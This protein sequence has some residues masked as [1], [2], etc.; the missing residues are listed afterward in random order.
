MKKSALSLILMLTSITSHASLV[1]IMDSGTD[2]SNSKLAAKAWV[3]SKEVVGMQDRDGDGLA[4][5]KFGWDF[6]TNSA[7]FFDGKYASAYREDAKKFFETIAKYDQGIISK[8]ELEWLKTAVKNEKLMLLT[9]FMGVYNHGT[10]VAGIASSGSDLIKIMPLKVLSAEPPP[11]LFSPAPTPISIP[12]QKPAG[13]TGYTFERFRDEVRAEARNNV[14]ELVKKV[15]VLNF[16]KV[17]TA[18]QSYGI[19]FKNVA[20][21]IAVAYRE[22]FAESITEQ[23]LLDLTKDFFKTIEGASVAVG[24]ANPYTLFVISAGNDS[25]N[26]DQL[27]AFPANIKIENKITVAATNGYM[28]LADFSNY[29]ANNVDVAA[30]GVGIQSTAVNQSTVY[31]SGTSQAAPFVTNVVARVKDIN[32]MLVARDIKKLVMQTVDKK[33]WL[34]GKVKSA[35]VV[36]L[37]RALKAAELSKTKNLDQAILDSRVAVADVATV[38]G[39]LGDE[40]E[41]EDLGRTF[42]YSPQMRPMNPIFQVQ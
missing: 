14:A 29:G 25:L 9:D 7:K 1:A 37:N 18:N 34:Q 24:K 12:A 32:P 30:P 39:F 5:D 21:F 19:S 36:N 23:V 3:N 16:H 20:G 4:G 27:G 28:S 26:N 31:M 8:S 13:Q 10:H 22:I 33:T 11:G 40:R 35:G 41:K 17:D 6:T 42:D 15:S 38:K 2:T